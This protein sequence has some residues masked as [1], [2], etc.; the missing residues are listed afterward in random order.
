MFPLIVFAG[1]DSLDFFVT[2]YSLGLSMSTLAL[3]LKNDVTFMI[4]EN[5]KGKCCA[6]LET[7]V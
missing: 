6:M 1:W 2:L 3:K 7:T 4:L 5:V